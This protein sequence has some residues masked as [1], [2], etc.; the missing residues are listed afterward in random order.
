[1]IHTMKA[2]RTLATVPG[3]SGQQPVPQPVAMT[4]ATR[5]TAAARLGALADELVSLDLDDANACEVARREAPVAEVHDPVDLGRLACGPPLPRERRILAGA[6]DQ[7]V[8]HGAGERSAAFPG[9]AVLIFLHERG[10]FRRDLG[11]DLVGI[12]GRRRPLFGRVGENA[13]AVEAGLVQKFEEI[14]ERGLRI[15]RGADEHSR[16][17]REAPGRLAV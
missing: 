8:R 7:D 13:E 14:L 2:V 16:A 15:A 3:A 1:M 12:R 4:S 10:A 11:R 9:E 17:D 5:S 6:V